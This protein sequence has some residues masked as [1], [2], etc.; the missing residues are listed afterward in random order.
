[1]VIVLGVMWYLYSLV[2]GFKKFLL[3]WLDINIKESFFI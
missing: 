2:F 3:S 1:M